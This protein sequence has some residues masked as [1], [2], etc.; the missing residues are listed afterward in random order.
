MKT[1]EAAKILGLDVS[2]VRKW[3]DHSTLGPYFSES[4]KG[5][6]GNAHRLLTEADVLVLNT[7]RMLRTG[8]NADW[9][10]IGIHL[11]TGGREQEF[12]QN[13]ISVDT[14]M[15]PIPQAKQAAEYMAVKAELDITITKINEIE[16]EN[17]R[18]RQEK[19]ELQ[20]KRVQETGDLRQKI[21]RLEAQVEM[22][23]EMLK[24]GE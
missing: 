1:G 9:D 13:A 23:R 12:P 14:R 3:I 5:K 24:K 21:G 20:E 15:I 19:D 10:T 22:L 8:Q 17:T 11:G 18:L 16:I 2:T 4:A 6:H 7:I